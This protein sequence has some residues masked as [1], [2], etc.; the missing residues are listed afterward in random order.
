LPQSA[1][2]SSNGRYIELQGTAEAAPFGRDLL[3]QMLDLA[4]EGIAR[5]IELQRGVIGSLE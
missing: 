3:N 4:D 1:S 5:L 2:A